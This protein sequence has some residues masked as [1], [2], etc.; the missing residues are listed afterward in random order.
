MIP[1]PLLLR[2]REHGGQ[3][4]P[5]PEVTIA[6]HHLRRRQPAPLEVA[7]SG[8]P[9]PSSPRKARS[10]SPWASPCRYSSGS[11]RPTSSVRRLNAVSTVAHREPLGVAH[12]EPV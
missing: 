8:A 4:A 5:D 6:D 7:D 11:N 1:T 12:M 2:L 10:K 3:R 9:S